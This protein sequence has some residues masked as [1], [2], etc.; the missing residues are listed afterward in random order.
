MNSLDE[1][2]IDQDIY[3]LVHFNSYLTIV[4]KRLLKQLSQRMNQSRAE[5][6]R[7]GVHYFLRD[8]GLDDGLICDREEM[9]ES[10]P[11][12]QALRSRRR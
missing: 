2:Q 4:Q 3:K 11:E 6:V 7:K 9:L 12:I 5:L 10:L 1:I 8:N